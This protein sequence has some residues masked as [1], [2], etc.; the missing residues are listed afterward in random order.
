MENGKRGMCIIDM[1]TTGVRIDPFDLVEDSLY[2]YAPN[3][4]APVIFAVLIAV[5]TITHGYQC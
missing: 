1:P 5:S 2:F 4:V 3:K